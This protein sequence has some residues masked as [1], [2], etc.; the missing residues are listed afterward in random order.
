MSSRLP[1]PQPASVLWAIPTALITTAGVASLTGWP[2]MALM[3]LVVGVAAI[4]VVGDVMGRPDGLQ[5][6]LDP[7]QASDI[8]AERDRDG[9]MAAIRLLRQKR[10]ELTL[11]D[12]VRLVRDL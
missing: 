9:E 7:E 11:A 5:P 3:F 4:V 1:H 12:V 10:P 8:R 6:W 2:V